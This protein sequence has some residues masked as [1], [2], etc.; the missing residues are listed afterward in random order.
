MTHKQILA[1]LQ[2]G[3]QLDDARESRRDCYPMRKPAP[4]T[5]V[6]RMWDDPLATDRPDRPGSAKAASSEAITGR[7][8][9]AARRSAGLDD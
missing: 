1:A 9:N 7:A 5:T 3:Y 8:V 6:R 2:L 4:R